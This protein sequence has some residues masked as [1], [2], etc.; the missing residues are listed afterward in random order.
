MLYDDANSGNLRQASGP[1]WVVKSVDLTLILDDIC[2][3]GSIPDQV[4]ESFSIF[5]SWKKRPVR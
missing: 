1:Y 2:T 3:R 4:D 5:V